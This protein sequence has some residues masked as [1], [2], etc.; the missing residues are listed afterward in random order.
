MREGFIECM[1]NLKMKKSEIKL[2]T[3]EEKATELRKEG[4][5][6]IISS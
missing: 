1:D 3:K 6:G 2:F 5:E 4:D